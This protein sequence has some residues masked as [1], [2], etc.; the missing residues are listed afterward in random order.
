MIVFVTFT[1]LCALLLFVVIFSSIHWLVKIGLIAVVFAFCFLVWSAQNSGQGYPAAQ[2]FPDNAQFVSCIV[3]EPDKSHGIGGVIY[4]WMIPLRHDKGGVFAY[5]PSGLEPRA[6]R[7][8]YD[9]DL[10]GACQKAQKAAAS[11]EP[12]RLTK[13]KQKGHKRAQGDLGAISE[14]GKYRVMRLPP[15]L[16]PRK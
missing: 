4:L 2:S 9:E 10:Q 16:P 13:M 5:R 7:E 11:G 12:V 15:V 6:Y 3:V 1:V 14:A 8:P